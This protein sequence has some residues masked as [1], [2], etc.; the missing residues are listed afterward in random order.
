MIIGIY[1]PKPNMG[2]STL[3]RELAN[4]AAARDRKVLLVELEYHYPSAAIEWGMADSKRCLERAIA[5][6]MES[7]D[8]RLEKY[9]L[10]HG[11]SNNPS[12]VPQ[13]R[14]KGRSSDLRMLVPSGMRGFEHIPGEPE[15]FVPEVCRQAEQLG[16]HWVILDISSDADSMLTISALRHVDLCITIHD[17]RIAHRTLFRHRWNLL[18]CLGWSSPVIP[19]SVRLRPGKQR[20]R[21]N[22][23]LEDWEQPRVAFPYVRNSALFSFSGWRYR[24]A[25]KLLFRLIQ[26][27][28]QQTMV[29]GGDQR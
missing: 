15:S 10:P 18:R 13:R 27:M 14:T 29:K 1:A 22:P 21:A 9:L 8:W 16:F 12:A 20:S 6:R 17:D 5:D 19:V 25:L 3:A 2:A 23:D 7:D 4:H 24:K 11:P 28:E 26:R